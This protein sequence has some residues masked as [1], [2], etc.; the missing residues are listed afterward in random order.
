M[1]LFFNKRIEDLSNQTISR[2]EHL[3]DYHNDLEVRSKIIEIQ[4]D[5]GAGLD[6]DELSQYLKMSRDEIIHVHSTS[7]YRIAMI[8]F[9][10][11]FIYLDGMPETLNCPRKANPRKSVP[12]GS[13]GIAGKQTGIYGLVSPGG[14]Q[15]I[16]LSDHRFNPEH[17]E[18]GLQPGDRVKFIPI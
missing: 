3:F 4:V 17:I 13:V 6:W 15:I 2:V 16:G 8:G 7:E 9:L 18:D 12:A 10:P 11:G 1:A 14:W 5:Y